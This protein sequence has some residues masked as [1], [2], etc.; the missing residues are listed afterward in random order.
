MGGGGIV[1]QDGRISDI[2]AISTS[3]YPRKVMTVSINGKGGSSGS[4]VVDYEGNII[5]VNHAGSDIANYVIP[6]EFVLEDL[7]YLELGQLPPKKDI[8]LTF[9]HIREGEAKKFYN[10]APEEGVIQLGTHTD[11]LPGAQSRLLRV[12]KC[13]PGSSGEQIF[14]PGDIITHVENVAVGQ[15]L[16]KYYHRLNTHDG[17][18]IQITFFRNGERRT[19]TVPLFDLNEASCHE[20]IVFGKAIFARANPIISLL[21]S[22]E[23]HAYLLF[24]W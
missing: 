4:M 8:G 19:E 13:L 17:D 20:M 3:N 18:T 23:S 11:Q 9:G 14:E 16:F 10:Y 1:L 6:A 24:L 15:D 5:G 22:I 21:F 7:H 12:T 2:C